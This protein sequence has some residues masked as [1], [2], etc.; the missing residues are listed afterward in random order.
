MVNIA[1]IQSKY[2]ALVLLMYDIKQMNENVFV[3][4]GAHPQEVVVHVQCLNPA[5]ESLQGYE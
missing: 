2:Q 1:G 5:Q 3:I 4:T